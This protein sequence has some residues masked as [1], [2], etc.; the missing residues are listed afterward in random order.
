[1]CYNKYSMKGRVFVKVLNNKQLLKLL[2]DIT[3][4]ELGK[5]V[6]GLK[7]IGGG[8]FGKVFKGI[9]SDGELI[10]LKVYRIKDM[11]IN[12]A[13][14]L[15]ILSKNTSVTMPEV[16]FTYN[17]TQVEMMAM[18]F[19]EGSNALNPL[20]LLKSRDKKQYFAKSVISGMAEL[21]SVTNNKFGPVDNPTYDSWLEFY[22]ETILTPK[23]NGLKE[24]SEKG[25]YSKRKFKILQQAAEF[26]RNNI[27]EPENA[28]LIHGDL[29]IMNIMADKKTM[30]LKGFI[31]PCNTLWAD[32]EY[33]LFQLLN[34]WG[35]SFYLYDTYKSKSQMSK[36]CDFKVAFF[37]AINEAGC[38]L[39][40]GVHMPLWEILCFNRLKKE[41]KK[42]GLLK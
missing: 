39:T 8:S 28:V 7:F 35:N 23:L 32:R 1:M 5:D 16:F 17:D 20:F 37:G 4:N 21:H 41:M 12:E 36:Y 27:E 26:Y 25:K 3:K 38:L 19:I 15:K 22:E 24:L 31:D 14:Q 6:T 40:S 2:P 42:L 29:N 34:M 30:K 13:N 9:M 33:D 11:N 18:S 10:I